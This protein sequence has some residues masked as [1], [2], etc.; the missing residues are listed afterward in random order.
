[1]TKAS[2]VAVFLMLAS[3]VVAAQQPSTDDILTWI[4][5]HLET[6]DLAAVVDGVSYRYHNGT[7]IEFQGCRVTVISTNF[8]T[9]DPPK[10]GY[11][12]NRTTT[13][14]PIELKN[15]RPESE[16]VIA[17]GRGYA[18]QVKGVNAFPET[19]V[20]PMLGDGS[21]PNQ[22]LN[23]LFATEDMANRQ[24]KAWRDAIIACGGKAVPDG[25]Y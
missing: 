2:A 5:S 3:V 11:P 8:V 4:G 24:A 20:D 25:L 6:V 1:M 15:L 21:G 14:G 22:V 9:V 7:R 13:D 16:K 10:Q 17:W 19:W 12:Y 23:L 18:L